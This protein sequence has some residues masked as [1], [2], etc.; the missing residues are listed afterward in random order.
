MISLML[1]V[2]CYKMTFWNAPCVAS[3]TAVTCSHLLVRCNRQHFLRL[4]TVLSILMAVKLLCGRRRNFV[5]VF[6]LSM[7]YPNELLVFYAFL[8]HL[9]DIG[10]LTQSQ[11][12]VLFCMEFFAVF[13]QN[14]DSH[15]TS[16]NEID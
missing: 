14:I 1:L 6:F 2:S 4:T 8:E 9:L 5:Q 12:R 7:E 13:T 16:D 3:V 10:R 15:K 11:N